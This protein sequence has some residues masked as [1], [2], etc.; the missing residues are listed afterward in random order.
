MARMIGYMVTWTTYGSWLQG[1]KRG[2]VAD[3]KIL[4]NNE[5]LRKE[6]I[7]KL[8]SPVVVLTPNQQKIVREAILNK[9]ESLNQKIYSIV[10]HS[11]HVH[12]VAG[13]T[14]KLIEMIVSHYKNAAR[15]ALRANGFKGKV[16]TRG[17]D[18]RY[19]FDQQQL[20]NRI[21][22]VRQHQK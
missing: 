18:K 20:K 13:K 3:G 21:E 16:W 19:C 1:D 2:Y 4:Q 12:I 15:L 17:F 6:N 9:A 8:K 22:Y 5:A 7:E 14:S 11:K 10:V